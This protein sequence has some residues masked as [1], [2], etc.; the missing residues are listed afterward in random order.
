MTD[1]Q[2]CSGREWLWTFCEGEKERVGM[3]EGVKEVVGGGGGGGGG[4]EKGGT[5]Y[6][7]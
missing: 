1:S 4:G 3:R 5:C 6:V 2:I 7:V